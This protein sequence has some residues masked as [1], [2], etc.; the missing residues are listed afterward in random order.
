MFPH[1]A[2]KDPFY[3]LV[4][5]LVACSITGLTMIHVWPDTLI[6]LRKLAKS[7][8][9]GVEPLSLTYDQLSVGKL[10]GNYI[11]GI[12]A[13]GAPVT[14]MKLHISHAHEALG[15]KRC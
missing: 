5:L 10:S 1:C 6:G 11:W 2:S 12:Y 14:N 3:N 8:Q 9:D 7:P 15:N 4:I 13:D